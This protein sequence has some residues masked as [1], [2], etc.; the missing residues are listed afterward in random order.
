MSKEKLLHERL[1]VIEEWCEQHTIEGL[2]YG[3]DFEER[4]KNLTSRIE[5]IEY[6][7]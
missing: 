3:D 7:D 4:D 6:R 1:T 2:E 5:H